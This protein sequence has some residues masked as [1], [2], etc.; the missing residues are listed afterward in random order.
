MHLPTY[1]GQG[2]QVNRKQHPNH[3]SVWTS[4]DSTAGRSRTIAVQL[5]PPLVEVVAVPSTRTTTFRIGPGRLTEGRRVREL[6]ILGASPACI[7]THPSELAVALVALD[8]VVRTLGPA[9][10]R[11]IPLGDLHRLCHQFAMRHQ[12]LREPGVV[13]FFGL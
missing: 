5:F 1:P 7:A 12:P 3:F 10:E 6:A 8:A 2:P 13:G 4:T 9:G 11:T